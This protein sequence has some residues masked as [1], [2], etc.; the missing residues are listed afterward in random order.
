MGVRADPPLESLRI[1]ERKV[2]PA[3]EPETQGGLWA[4]EG[5]EEHRPHWSH[6]QLPSTAPLVTELNSVHL[7]QNSLRHRSQLYLHSTADFDELA[8]VTV[9]GRT[10]KNPGDSHYPAS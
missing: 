8:Q 3:G 5:C 9:R 1:T 2:S 4:G 7:T 6:S 10:R